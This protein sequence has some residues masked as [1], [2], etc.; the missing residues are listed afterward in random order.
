MKLINKITNKKIINILE[1]KNCIKNKDY[2]ISNNGIAIT[3][4]TFNTIKNDI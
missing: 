1:L 2:F 4:K 3:H